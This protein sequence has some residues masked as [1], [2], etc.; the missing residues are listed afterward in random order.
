MPPTPTIWTKKRLDRLRTLA[1]EG[2]TAADISSHISAEL[3]EFV[4]ENAVRLQ[5]SRWNIPIMGRSSGI[6]T[7][8]SDPF[9]CP[10][11]LEKQVRQELDEEPRQPRWPFT[12]FSLPTGPDN[13]RIFDR[14]LELW[15]EK[16][17]LSR[18][19]GYVDE[20]VDSGSASEGQGLVAI[21][22]GPPQWFIHWAEPVTMQ[23][24][25]P[26][27]RK[28]SEEYR[29][30][31]RSMIALAPESEQ[32]SL[33]GILDD[34]MFNEPEPDVPLTWVKGGC[35]GELVEGEEGLVEELQRRVANYPEKDRERW[36]KHELKVIVKES[37]ELVAENS[38]P[39]SSEPFQGVVVDSGD[40]YGEPESL[41]EDRDAGSLVHLPSVPLKD[42]G[43]LTLP[44]GV[45]ILGEAPTYTTRDG[46]HIAVT[47]QVRRS[48][49]GT[50]I[51]GVSSRIVRVPKKNLRKW[52]AEYVENKELPR[53]S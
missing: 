8:P 9:K 50:M 38:P 14:L 3:G 6:D 52:I 7:E 48:G 40:G 19:S 44:P 31:L 17:I 35:H 12:L 22:T 11:W 1:A 47:L 24:W 39:D 28:G 26:I 51:E 15:A 36:M 30:K 16:E 21:E 49:R 43:P 33:T 53:G 23:I 45:T 27:G 41:V 18:W 4:S 5:A 13:Q 29:D 20:I 46:S 10:Q 32:P 25:R 42:D 34:E 2:Y 37:A